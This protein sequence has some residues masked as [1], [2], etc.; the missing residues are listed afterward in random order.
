[1]VVAA[2]KTVT[3][4]V[5]LTAPTRRVL[6]KRAVSLTVALSAAKIKRSLT[7]RR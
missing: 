1:V 7:V 4:H 2:A 6:R 3:L 5:K